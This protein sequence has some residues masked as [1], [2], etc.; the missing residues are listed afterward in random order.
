MKQKTSF[1]H[2]F[3]DISLKIKEEYNLSDLKFVK[4][5]ELGGIYVLFCSFPNVNS[6]EYLWDKISSVI[7]SRI[8]NKLNND[9]ERWNVYLFLSSNRKSKPSIQ[10]KIENDT[11]FCR[12][13]VINDGV[14]EFNN[15]LMTKYIDDYIM[16]YDITFPINKTGKRNLYKPQSSIY[17]IIDSSEDFK[18]DDIYD[19]LYNALLIE[20]GTK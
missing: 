17:E 7:A 18:V 6:M 5:N 2:V 11:F 13:I 1:E 16:N 19:D 12:K 9:F 8:S 10:Y 3:D 15:D 4:V 14:S 20:W